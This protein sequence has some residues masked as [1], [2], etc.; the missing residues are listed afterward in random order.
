MAGT[1]TSLGP[2]R[3]VYLDHAAT[4]P[5]RAVA[6][7]AV[8]A[9]LGAT[10][11]P[12]SLH[13][14]GRRAARVVEEARETVARSLHARPSEVVF[15]SGGTESDN[16]ALKGIH[17]ARRRG[18]A[19]RTRILTTAV[20]HP[21][22]LETVRWL[23]QHGGAVVELLPV[24]RHGALR[25]EELA[26]TV[27]RDP[28]SVSLISVMWANHEVGTLQPI[29]DVVRIAREYGVPVHS[30]A[31]AAV[32]QVPVD[33]ARSGVDALS[34]AAHKFGGPQGAGALLLRRDL[35][36]E[37]GLHGGG[38]ELGLRSGTPSVALLAGLAAALA[39]AVEDQQRHASR[40]STLRDRLVRLARH[41]VPGT[42]LNGDPGTTGG[43]LPGNVNLHLPGCEGDSLVMLLDARGVEVST[44][45]ACTSGVPRPSHVLLA[46]GANE[47]DARANLRVTLGHTTTQEDVDAFVEALPHVVGRARAFPTRH[48]RL[49]AG[50]RSVG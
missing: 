23:E 28:A 31:V 21:A 30:D 27:E 44:G 10:G 43:R 8:T 26:A 36:L 18:D 17:A 4:T 12:A 50:G 45:S 16:L 15:T 25:V 42:S 20:E 47:P 46:M 41:A 49:V 48:H 32:G 34:L 40:V 3:T 29:A 6:V 37:P 1:A 39:A 9:H 38:A 13:S 33:F 5:M 11:N 14:T 22:V 2:P 35:L 24:D 7:A 19:R